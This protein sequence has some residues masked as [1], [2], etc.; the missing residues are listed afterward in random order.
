LITTKDE[1]IIKTLTGIGEI[2]E[3]AIK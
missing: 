1:I 2:W 3:Q